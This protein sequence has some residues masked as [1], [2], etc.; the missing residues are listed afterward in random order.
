MVL[1]FECA[2][3]VHSQASQFISLVLPSW[4]VQGGSDKLNPRQVNPNRLESGLYNYS[5]FLVFCLCLM[6]LY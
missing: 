6:P 3:C 2:E 4:L 1:F 5:L